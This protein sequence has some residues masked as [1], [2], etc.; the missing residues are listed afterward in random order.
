MDEQKRPEDLTGMETGA[1]KEYIIQHI[2]ALK[3]TERQRAAAE[4]EQAKWASRAS[5]ARS[6]G[7]ED[8]AARA[9]AEAAGRRAL[10]ERLGAEMEA[11]KA[12]I[13]T[14]RRQLP[15]L[16]ARERAV[17]ADLLLEKL[18]Q[19]AGYDSSQDAERERQFKEL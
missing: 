19:E 10:A 12:S 13:E 14:M 15:A 7:R 6:K 4:A 11:L 1:A 17:D 5:L 9:E 8:L 3:E 18:A 2:A 16:A